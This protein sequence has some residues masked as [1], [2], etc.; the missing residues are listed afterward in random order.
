MPAVVLQKE[1]ICRDYVRVEVTTAAVLHLGT[2]Y[3]TK[4][5]LTGKRCSKVEVS[6]EGAN[7]ARARQDGGLPSTGASGNG[8]PLLPGANWAFSGP[9]NVAALRLIGLDG[10]AVCH[11]SFYYER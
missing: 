8:V 2:T 1:L 11:I 5:N 7:S 3:P 9:M 6:V 4:L 10:T